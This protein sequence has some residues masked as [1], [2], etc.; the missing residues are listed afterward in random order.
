[1]L[2][3]I[4]GS[5]LWKVNIDATAWLSSMLYAFNKQITDKREGEK[6]VTKENCV[7]KT[8]SFVEKFLHFMLDLEVVPPLPGFPNVCL[9]HTENPT[10]CTLLISD[11]GFTYFVLYFPAMPLFRLKT[12][13]NNV[14]YL[15]NLFNTPY[16][17]CPLGGAVFLE[18]PECLNYVK[19]NSLKYKTRAFL[20]HRNIMLI[21]RYF[22]ITMIYFN[23]LLVISIAHYCFFNRFCWSR[24]PHGGASSLNQLHPRQHMHQCPPD[25]QEKHYLIPS[26]HPFR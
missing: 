20:G 22:F 10:R 25:G 23:S 6:Q 18:S 17:L 14:W 3:L 1:M 15:S 19:K 24:H 26:F 4:L 5:S 9:K 7:Q 8:F 21:L 13:V 11:A 12:K 2:I 16:G